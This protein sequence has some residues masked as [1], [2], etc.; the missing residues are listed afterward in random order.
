MGANLETVSA[1]SRRIRLNANASVRAEVD[2][3]TDVEAATVL[4]P[5]PTRGFSTAEAPFEE[6]LQLPEFAILAP[7][8]HGAMSCVYT[9]IH[10]ESSQRYAIKVMR[11]A[12][13][14]ATSL[15]ERV[16]LES[17]VIRAIDHPHVARGYGFG[18]LGSAFYV[19][20]ELI[21]GISLKRL[22]EEDGPL[23]PREAADYIAQAADG[24]AAAHAKGIV[25]RDIKPSNLLLDRNGLIK[26]IDFGMARVDWPGQSSITLEHGDTL[27]GTVDYMAPEQANS[28]HDA[29]ARADLYSL[30][31]TL[32]YLLTGHPPFPEGTITARLI[33]HCHAEPKPLQQLRADV[34]EKLAAICEG[35]MVKEPD[36]RIQSALEVRYALQSWLKSSP[37]V[38]RTSGEEGRMYVDIAERTTRG[39]TPIEE[40]LRERK[41]I[42]LSFARIR[43]A[44]FL[45]TV[46]ADDAGISQELANEL[47]GLRDH[48]ALLF[49]LDPPNSASEIA[50][51]C[52]HLALEADLLGSERDEL[53]VALSDLADKAEAARRHSPRH[54]AHRNLEGEFIAFESR[55]LEHQI[56]EAELTNHTLYDEIGVGD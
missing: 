5:R 20:M 41:A 54:S 31:C 27:L 3:Q 30:G 12:A 22:V 13:S 6:Q 25:H 15:R 51:T 34:P 28:C 7:L 29:D 42:Q 44:F 50:S 18:I 23:D 47:N 11:I 46:R 21:H 32:Y 49:T 17:R 33:K 36:A 55:F 4:T 14:Q 39:P 16:E 10:R 43:K 35:M 2:R 9:A 8:A 24:L 40:I 53:F 1:R 37:G 56:R 26:V 45:S 19:V 48:A 38:R 52:P